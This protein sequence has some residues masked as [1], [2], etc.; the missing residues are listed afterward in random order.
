MFFEPFV[1]GSMYHPSSVTEANNGHL[2]FLLFFLLSAWL[3]EISP[4]LV[5]GGGGGGIYVLS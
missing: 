5:S 1:T 2:F 3:A 4:V